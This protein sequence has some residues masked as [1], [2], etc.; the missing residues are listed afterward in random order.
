MLEGAVLRYHPSI[1]PLAATGKDEN[2]FPSP[3]ISRQ[4][5]SGI[6]ALCM[7]GGRHGIHSKPAA[8]ENKLKL[9]RD[10]WWK[11]AVVCSCRV[12]NSAVL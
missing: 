9:S 6:T 7:R 3:L 10:L 1:E 12:E 11:Y 8:V 4:N 5:P 2:T